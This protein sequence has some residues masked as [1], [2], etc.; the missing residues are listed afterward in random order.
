[1]FCHG[2]PILQTQNL[3][4]LVKRTYDQLSEYKKKFRSLDRTQHLVQIDHKIKTTTAIS[5]LSSLNFP[6]YPSASTWSMPELSRMNEISSNG[7]IKPSK[8]KPFNSSK[9]IK[10]PCML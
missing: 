6:W 3:T 9:Q 5:T 10:P 1:M 4:I 8:K 7:Q 2:L